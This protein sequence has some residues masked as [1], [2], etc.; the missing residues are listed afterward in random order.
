MLD[1]PIRK[2]VKNYPKDFTP[3]VGYL[4]NSQPPSSDTQH[5]SDRPGHINRIS[6]NRF[7]HL[8]KST[9]LS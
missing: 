2:R 7:E 8:N 9:Q 4:T 6:H 5:S 3:P 1:T